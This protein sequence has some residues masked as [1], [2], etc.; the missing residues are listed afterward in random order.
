M[1]QSESKN[2]GA[3]I[4]RFVG[5]DFSGGAQ[6]WRAS[7]SRPTVWIAI[8]ED[9]GDGLILTDLMPVQA[10]E[11]NDA[12]FDRLV[13]LLRSADFEAAAID[14]PFSLPL[15]HMPPGGHGELLRQVAALPDASDR[16]FPLAGSILA[17]GENVAPKSQA[18]PLR[19]TEAYW[20]SKGVNTRSTMWAGPRGGAAFTAA[21]L[22]LLAR[23][24][25]PCWPWTTF[26]PGILVEAF[27]AAQLRH[28]SLPHQGYSKTKGA[29]IRALILAGLDRRLRV[30]PRHG[31]TIVNNPDAL[32]AVVA[33]FAAIGLAN[34]KIAGFNAPY[35]DGCIAVA[36]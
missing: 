15:C 18:K 24:G 16:P 35:A 11:G 3:P 30:S 17:L 23:S 7:V 5:I 13:N 10:L 31:Q 29:S 6:P 9:S 33:A 2:E 22:R 34:G 25:Q 4:L 8:V 21:C 12:P 19:Q 26:R 32:D 28:W 1:A 27:P 36:E 14:A 20:A